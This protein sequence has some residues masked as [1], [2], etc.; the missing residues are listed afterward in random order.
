MSFRLYMNMTFDVRHDNRQFEQIVTAL[1]KRFKDY[2]SDV[3]CLANVRY[4]DQRSGKHRQYD[5]LILERQC[6]SVVE[7]K[8]M[9][10]MVNGSVT[11]NRGN[12]PLSIT[13]PDGR[14]GEIRLD[15]I[16]SQK[17]YLLRLFRDELR[18]LFRISEKK[19][20]DVDSYLVC[21]PETD[22]SNVYIDPDNVGRWFILTTVDQFMHAYE[23]R[24]RRKRFKL[25]V[26]NLNYIAERHFRLNQVDPRTY[27][28]RM[29]SVSSLLSDLISDLE[30]T[31]DGEYTADQLR[32]D[33][34]GSLENED[35]L[36]QAL[37]YAHDPS[38]GLRSPD[39]PEIT[40][41]VR[42]AKKI[43]MHHTRGIV[44]RLFAHRLAEFL[45]HVNRTL[46]DEFLS[47]RDDP[48]KDTFYVVDKLWLIMQQYQEILGT[49]REIKQDLRAEG[50]EGIE[51]GTAIAQMLQGRAAVRALAFDW[52]ETGT[53]TS[54]S[55]D[56]RPSTVDAHED[57]SD[58]LTATDQDPP[59]TTS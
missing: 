54:S 43:S 44:E 51:S 14:T 57:G 32:D 48:S 12:P 5:L 22:Y 37:A 38:P 56:A 17:G 16:E 11:L 52:R 8:A 49:Y 47:L 29:K 50:P 24:T 39:G 7:L 28:L 46:V 59:G 13:F 41:F 18:P 3:Y 27:W 42:A 36:A 53:P 4:T 45:V 55:T 30:D 1:H 23:T 33:L 15:Q 31:Y 10:G 40:A 21:L 6:I 26:G 20:F 58:R 35:E 9:S 2:G 19:K 34:L 25:S